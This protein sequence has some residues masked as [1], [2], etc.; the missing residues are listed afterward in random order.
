[1]PWQHSLSSVLHFEPRVLVLAVW[2]PGTLPEQSVLSQENELMCTVSPLNPKP[3]AHFKRNLEIN[4]LD[5]ISSF[6]TVINLNPPHSV[7]QPVL[8]RGGFEW[9]PY[10]T[11]L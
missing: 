2:Q 1:M 9:G 4:G 10:F 5:K 11:H 7:L 8:G 6:L 3:G